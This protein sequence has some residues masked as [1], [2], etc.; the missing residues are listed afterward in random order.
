MGSQTDDTTNGDDPFV[1]EYRIVHIERRTRTVG[2]GVA[3][4][5]KQG[6]A[7][8]PIGGAILSS[9]ADHERRVSDLAET[10]DDAIDA[11][12]YDHGDTIAVATWEDADDEDPSIEWSVDEPEGWSA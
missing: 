2:P 7:A 6:G 5:V 9:S 8:L 11:E 3:W 10:I 1:I 12:A 4:R